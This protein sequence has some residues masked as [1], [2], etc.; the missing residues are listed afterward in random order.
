MH[1]K[2]ADL[3]HA[4]R[5]QHPSWQDVLRAPPR[6][7]HIV[8]ICDNDDVLV[9]GAGYFVS[10]GL[11]AGEAVI[12]T[13]T[14]D[15]MNGIRR[16]L[17]SRGANPD[18]YER[19]GQLVFTDAEEAVNYVLEG[20]VPDR[21]RFEALAASVMEPLYNDTRWAGLRWW[22]EMSNVFNKRGLETAVLHDEEIGDG[23]C[24]KYGLRLMC[25]F[26]C[27]RFDPQ[28]YNGC[29]QEV[30]ARHTHVIPAEDYALHRVAVNR[31]VSDVLGEI[32]GA[33]L[34]SLLSWKAL[35]CEMPS[36]QAVLFW[37]RD[38]M[39]EYLPAVLARAR[40]Y[41]RSTMRRTEVGG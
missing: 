32:K 9:E 3:P 34:Q 38:T 14:Q 28:N 31:A 7:A 6:P 16:V 8:Q 36:S 2:T 29:L 10:E 40:A 22:G 24:R 12:L 27:D 41:H 33:A 30:C 21:A 23:I 35:R 4:L 19:R 18:I 26:Q 15:H 5:T 17:R 13:G 39:P 37:L 1:T 25:S 20:N 11:D